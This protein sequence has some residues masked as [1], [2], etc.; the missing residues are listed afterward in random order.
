[1]MPSSWGLLHLGVYFFRFSHV[2]IGQC[3][4]FWKTS[5]YYS[6]PLIYANTWNLV[7][8]ASG[9]GQKAAVS[10][11]WGKTCIPTIAQPLFLIYSCLRPVAC[12]IVIVSTLE[13]S[14]APRL[15]SNDFAAF[16]EENPWMHKIF[17]HRSYWIVNT[18]LCLHGDGWPCFVRRTRLRVAE[19]AVRIVPQAR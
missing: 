3:K 2:C 13:K 8:Q 14:S 10:I 16:Y 19:R 5:S 17:P 11:L 12:C 6:A 7:V 4:M 15:S 1:M 18:S 9:S